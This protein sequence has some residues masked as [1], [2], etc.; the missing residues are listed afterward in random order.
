MQNKWIGQ[1]MCIG[2]VNRIFLFESVINIRKT[3]QQHKRQSF[4][5]KQM[6]NYDMDIKDEHII[7]SSYLRT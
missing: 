4:L 2:Q 5:N 1:L 3:D 7:V 6:Y